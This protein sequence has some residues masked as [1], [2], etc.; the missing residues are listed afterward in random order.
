MSDHTIAR[1]RWLEFPTIAEAYQAGRDGV[2][3]GSNEINSHVRFF[4]SPELT[5]AWERGKRD[6]EKARVAAEAR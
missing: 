3:H 5:R 6:A 1:M 4:R 2:D